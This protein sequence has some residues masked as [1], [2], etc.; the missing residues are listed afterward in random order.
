MT[1]KQ[2]YAI[3]F[4]ESMQAGLLPV[5]PD[6]LSLGPQEV[7]GR[8]LA[9]LI[10][11]GT[12]L[13]VYQGLQAGVAYPC[14]TGYAA[15]FEVEQVGSEVEDIKPG[16][17]VLCMGP[18]RSHQRARREQCVRV[19]DGL[20]PQHAVFARLMG[21][22]MSTLATTNARPPARVLVTGLGPVGHLAAQIFAS[23]GYQVAACDPDAGRRAIASQHGLAPVLT[24]IADDP[25]WVRNIDLAVECSGHEAAVLEACRVARKGGEVVLVGVPWQRRSEISAHEILHEVFHRYIVLRSGWEWE[26]PLHAT[27]FR[28][29]SIY[30]NLEAALGWLKSRRI[31]VEDLHQTV[32]PRQAQEV[33]QNL[34]HHRFERLAVVFDWSDP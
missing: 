27:D 21:V 4:V 26:L 24:R 15:V 6:A 34:L 31:N 16:E 14:E 11:A 12:E 10:S 23:C 22:S 33:Y 8:T 25:Q 32:S 18:H 9:S 7:A 13:A 17:R 5:E 30:G 2:E 20:P 29:G 3:T 1:Q 19:P 28:R